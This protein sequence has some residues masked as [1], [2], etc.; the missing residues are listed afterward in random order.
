MARLNRRSRVISIRL[1][2]EEFEQLQTLCESKGIQS[3]SEIARSA[4][5]RLVLR[6]TDPN[7]VEIATRVAE[8][9]TRIGLLDREIERIAG[10]V[11]LARLDEGE[12]QDAEERQTAAATA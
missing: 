6:D 9:Q 2:D 7:N 12:K 5:R 8:M 1:S 10:Y 11:G 4:I 3:L